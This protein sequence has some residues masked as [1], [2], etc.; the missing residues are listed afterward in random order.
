MEGADIS[1]PGVSTTRLLRV[2]ESM[3]DLMS[4]FD[5]SDMRDLSS[6]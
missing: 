2:I 1:G 5:M 4:L 6:Y 3:T